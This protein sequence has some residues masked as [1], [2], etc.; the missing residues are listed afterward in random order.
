MLSA[1]QPAIA[2]PSR[3][4]A[5]ASL[6]KH[7]LE[8]LL[9]ELLHA[10]ALLLLRLLLSFDLQATMLLVAEPESIYGRIG[11][12]GL[13]GRY[14][15]SLLFYQGPLWRPLLCPLQAHIGI[16]LEGAVLAWSLLSAVHCRR[17]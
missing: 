6:L 12:G 11:L 1:R 14:R 15:E 17:R 4:R 13:D 8:H 16:E 10:I 7:I 3:P 2:G 9:E 5:T